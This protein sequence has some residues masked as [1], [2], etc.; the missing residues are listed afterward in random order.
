LTAGSHYDYRFVAVNTDGT[1]TGGNH[2]FVTAD[3]P[4]AITETATPSSVA[5]GDAFVI[6]GVVTGTLNAGAQV[7]LQSNPY[8]YTAGFTDIGN[9]EV[10]FA[11]GSFTFN[12]IDLS[13]STEYRV[14]AGAETSPVVVVTSPVAVSLKAK[15]EGSFFRP[16]VRFTGA[17]KPAQPNAE[18][19]IERWNG[20][21]WVV[22]G[23]T[24]AGNGLG[25]TA[26][27]LGSEVH[28]GVTLRIHRSGDFRALVLP[29]EGGHTN[30]Y[31]PA[32]FVRV[33]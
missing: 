11:N 33:R 13:V 9:P 28:F 8:P 14:V 27:T 5:L 7:Q 15:S 18:V 23:G 12:V 19:A 17:I 2:A 4:L 26:G 25:V 22:V 10:A 3:V 21:S 16:L 29:V 32:V 20:S 1:S 31:S 30:G 24:N 6:S